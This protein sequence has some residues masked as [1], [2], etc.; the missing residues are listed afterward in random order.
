LDRCRLIANWSKALEAK[1]VDGLTAD[2][3]PDAVLYDAIP[4]YK[5]VGVENIRKA[6]ESCL[7]YLPAFKSVL[8][9]FICE[10]RMD[11]TQMCSVV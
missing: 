3:A 10:A 2:Y 8:R 5:A 1:D 7:P 11:K 9:C 6:W 4:P